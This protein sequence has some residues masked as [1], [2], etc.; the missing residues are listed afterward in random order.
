[1]SIYN[2]VIP[3]FAVIMAIVITALP[4]SPFLGY[5]EQ[6]E[7]IPW[8]SVLN[9]FMP[10]PEM[11]AILQSWCIAYGTYVAYKALLKYIKVM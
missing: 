7:Q 5:I 10:I 9:W 6:V 2:N 8:L 1:M 3:F 4:A 11:I